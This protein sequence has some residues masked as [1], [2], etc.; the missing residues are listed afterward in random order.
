MQRSSADEEEAFLRA[1]ASLSM[2][3]GTRGPKS[4][5]RRRTSASS[6]TR[7]IAPHWPATVL[8]TTAARSV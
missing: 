1:E 3:R 5:P 7:S 4:S 8:T 2:V 6:A